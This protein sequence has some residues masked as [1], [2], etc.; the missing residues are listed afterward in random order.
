MSLMQSTVMPMNGY[1]GRPGKRMKVEPKGRLLL[2]LR[3]EIGGGEK[4]QVKNFPG[5]ANRPIV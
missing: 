1:G 2:F 4:I 5:R 3:L